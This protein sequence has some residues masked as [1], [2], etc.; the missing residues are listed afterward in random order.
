MAP[1]GTKV[2]VV[3]AADRVYRW[4]RDALY[5]QSYPPHE[6]LLE[7]KAKKKRPKAGGRRSRTRTSTT[8][9]RPRCRRRSS[10]NGATID[11]ALVDRGDQR[12]ARRGPSPVTTAGSHLRGV[13]RAG[14]L[15]Q[16]TLPKG[17]NWDGSRGLTVRAPRAECVAIDPPT[18]RAGRGRFQPDS[19]SAGATGRPQP[20]GGVHAQ[21]VNTGAS[22]TTALTRRH[23]PSARGPPRSSP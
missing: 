17:A 11:W 9:S 20:P 2:T 10:P 3:N 16:N 18:T 13:P 14:R 7:A 5:V 6:E 23:L 21:Q 19:A 15:V 1:V 4:Q 22:V 8:R 12:G